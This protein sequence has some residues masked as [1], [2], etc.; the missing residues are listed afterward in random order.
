[1][2]STT[3]LVILAIPLGLGVV[4]TAKE[5]VEKASATGIPLAAGA[6]GRD[7]RGR[8][9]LAAHESLHGLGRD[10]A[11]HH[12]HDRVAQETGDPGLARLTSA[13]AAR[14]RRI[15]TK[16]TAERSEDIVAA[17]SAK[18]PTE[19]PATTTGAKL[20]RQAGK[21]ARVVRAVTEIDPGLVTHDAAELLP[22][23]RRKLAQRARRNLFELVVRELCRHALVV[24]DR[25]FRGIAIG[26]VPGLH[27][28]HEIVRAAHAGLVVV[29]VI[30][31]EEPA[32][33]LVHY[34]AFR[35]IPR[36]AL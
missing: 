24:L 23:L 20:P 3:A 33:D 6:R 8:G 30:G 2:Q 10:Q 12:L 9:P 29:F 15:A 25:L 1:Q 5:R 26:L 22:L 18:Q 35:M 27:A 17:A 11:K 4:I 36:G 28:R 34:C 14:G 13:G 7:S 21:L 16:Q 19:Q 32:Q 31:P